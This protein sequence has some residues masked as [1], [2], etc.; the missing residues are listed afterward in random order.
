MA[1]Y[2]K[3]L[4]QAKLRKKLLS[5]VGVGK[6]GIVD[7]METSADEIVGLAKRVAPVVSGDLQDSIGWKW[8]APP[9]RKRI[10]GFIKITRPAKNDDFTITIF[11]GNEKAYYARWVEFGR[12][13]VPA[14]PFFYPAYRA[15]RRRARGRVTRAVN[16]AFKKVANS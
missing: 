13:G 16:K 9:K 3:I 15:S 8:G 5:L 12:P 1:T 2:A 4:G 11:A 14:S 10:L 6:L 7:A